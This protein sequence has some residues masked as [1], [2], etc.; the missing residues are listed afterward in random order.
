LREGSGTRV[1]AS[2]LNAAI[3]LQGEPLVNYFAGGKSRDVLKRDTHLATWFH[4]APYG[5]YP[6]RDGHVV[7]SLCDAATLAEALESDALREV[8]SLDRYVERDECARRLAQATT[9]HSVAELG[10]RFD[11]HGIWWAPINYYDQ[12][13]NDPQLAHAKVFR[14]VEL[15]GRTIQLVNHPNRYDGEVP[16]LR[17]LALEI[18]EHTREILTELGYGEDEIHGL[19]A[20]RAVVASRDAEEAVAESSERMAS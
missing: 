6:A 2:L 12:L 1:E 14:Q 7:V 15:R 13:L 9:P 11:H 5:V 18:G 19:L 17:V 3:D 16:E 8:A 10:E 20:A 4:G